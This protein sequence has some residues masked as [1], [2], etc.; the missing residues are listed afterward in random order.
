MFGVV[1]NNVCIACSNGCLNC[2]SAD[3]CYQCPSTSALY[4]GACVTSCPSPLIFHYN[5]TSLAFNC[6]TQ[7]QVNQQTLADSLQ[8][9]SIFPLPFT[10][11][12]TFFFL[13]CLMS[14]LQFVHTYIM[15]VGYAL[16][17]CSETGALIYLLTV[18]DDYP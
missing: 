1:T 8:V 13:C 5:T 7:D 3:F 10:I 12:T 4:S 16:Y 2:S 6:F 17:G 14:K 15:G 18:Y 9:S 11:L